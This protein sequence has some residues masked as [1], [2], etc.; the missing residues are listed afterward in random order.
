MKNI[1]LFT[2]GLLLTISH[3]IHAADNMNAFPPAEEG[4]IRNIIQLPK[5]DDESAFKLE[6]IV[7]KTVKID[8]A[9]RYFFSGSI[10]RETIKGWGYSRYI[11]GKL[12]PMAGTL[13][14][15][16]P[17]TPKADRFITLG[18]EPYLIH[19]NSRLPVVVYV[20]DG[21]EV[22]YRIWSAG[23]EVIIT[24]NPQP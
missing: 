20:P 17:N 2:L 10:E 21:V 8:H 3:P 1:V 11:V 14:A 23:D 7:G 18:G 4:M 12:G 19:Y 5:Q 22:R 24:N 9:N 15:V 6:I 16:D 13:M